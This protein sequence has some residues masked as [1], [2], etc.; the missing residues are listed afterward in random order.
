MKS[1]HILASLVLLLVLAVPTASS[2]AKRAL[3]DNTKAET[4]GNADWIIDTDQPMPLPDQGTVTPATPR[5][6]W[7]GAISSFG[8]DLVKRGYTVATL[9]TTYGITYGNASNPYD[10]S[11]YDVF[12]VPEPNSPFTTAEATAILGFVRDGGGL[13]AIADHDVSDRNGDGWDSPMVWNAMDPGHLLGVHWGS[14]G[15]VNANITQDSGNHAT[16]PSDSIIFGP[17]GVADSLS[18]HNGTTLTLYPGVN[19]SVRGEVWM[20]G[21]AQSSTT[22][23]MAASSVYGNGRVF[24]IGDSSPV[25]DGSAQPG[26]SSIYDGWG[27]AAGRDSLLFQNATMWATRRAVTTWTI[28]ASA[29]SN[30]SIAPSG[31]VVVT[32]GA[33]QAF[34][35]TPA[36]H[37]HVVDVL[38]DGN[39]VGAVSSYAFSNVTA[40]HTIAASFAIDTYP[41]TVTTGAHGVSAPGGTVNVPYGADQHLS[42]QPDAGYHVATLTVDDVAQ[43][44]DTT[45]TFTAVAAPHT[46]AAAFAG[47]PYS[48][49]ITLVGAGTVTRSP[50]AATYPNGTTVLVI[51]TPD[52]GWVF[53]GWSGDVTSTTDTVD[54]LVDGAKSLTATFVVDPLAVGDGPAVFALAP[55][56]P[57]PARGAVRLSFSLAAAGAAS[58]EVLDVS[59]RRVVTLAH[60]EYAAGPHELRWD[61]RDD[62]GHRLGAGMYFARLHAADGTR[63]RRFVRMD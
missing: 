6:Y 16:S 50:D 46:L 45:W 63:V 20:K 31:S 4:S 21:L 43:T 17:N 1:G 18:F 37:Y 35:I 2:A 59:G 30:G 56:L 57:N 44:P 62:G 48:L 12:I 13:I 38:V 53:S 3:F 7:L 26:N 5:T 28:G 14:T 33:S 22:G 60:G 29:G 15:D 27:E 49:G 58:V 9:T 52:T 55:A 36:A 39:S 54:V 10:L 25:D 19:P 8:I 23:V 51:A 11:K 24:F 34:T 40:N 61:G 41:I 32:Q 47:D 42:L